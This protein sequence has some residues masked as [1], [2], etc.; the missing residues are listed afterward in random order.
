M[1]RPGAQMEVHRPKPVHGLRELAKEI[2]IIVVGVL[3]ALG[4]EQAVEWSQR[5]AEVAD[6]H[7]ALRS[8]IALNARVARF[9]IEE[10]R[11]LNALV[12]RHIAWAKG[13]ARAP[14]GMAGQFPDVT[15]SAWEVVKVSAAAHMP[16][17]ERLAYA[18]IYNGVQDLHWAIENERAA[19]LRLYGNTGMVALAPSDAQRVLVDSTQAR[20]AIFAS[21]ATAGGLVLAARSMG[22]EPLPLSPAAR[23]A[24]AQTCAL[25]SE[26]AG[27]PSP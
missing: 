25:S 16:L 3:I 20:I 8:E 9:S 1:M 22:I 18:S 10:D 11:C 21:S 15:T 17:K 24:I 2:G 23:E 4:A 7:E 6:A 13:G 12:D 19:F 5:R 14:T 27:G 26:R